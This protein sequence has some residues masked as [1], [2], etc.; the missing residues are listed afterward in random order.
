VYTAHQSSNYKVDIKML[1]LI[2]SI[3]VMT[4]LSI[5]Y[6]I[7]QKKFNHQSNYR[8]TLTIK[9]IAENTN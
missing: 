8:E 3:M 2:K 6:Q 7:I 5:Q 1:T 4:L 9:L